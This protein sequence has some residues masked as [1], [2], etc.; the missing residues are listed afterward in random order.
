M[1]QS[2]SETQAKPLGRDFDQAAATW[3]QDP[4]RQERT[5][6]IA[7]QIIAAVPLQPD[8]QAMEYGCGTASLALLLAQHV[9]E[10]VAADASQGMID[11]VVRKVQACPSARVKPVRLDLERD[12]V[13]NTR[14]NLIVC[15]MSLHHIADTRQL[16]AKWSAMLADDGWLAV[17]DLCQEDGSFHAPVTV[18]HNGFAPDALQEM[19]AQVMGLIDSNYQ[20]IHQI[21]KNGR[22][23][24]VFLLVAHRRGCA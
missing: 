14:F 20:V 7:R 16:L 13:L 22:T 15:A 4:Q 21:D 18:P 8:W 19:M 9:R 6:V 11:Q 3:D 2:T 24:D 10:V 12:P 17:V 23:F 1:D 5:R